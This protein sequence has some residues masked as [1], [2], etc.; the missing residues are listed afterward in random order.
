MKTVN[1]KGDV[2]AVGSQAHRLYEEKKF[3]ELDLHMKEINSAYRS[4][5]G[6]FTVAAEASP[7]SEDPKAPARCKRCGRSKSYHRKPALLCPIGLRGPHGFTRFSDTD[8][9]LEDSDAR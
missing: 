4:L 8:T 5:H 6:T 7:D 1:Y 2:L 3:K 9:Y